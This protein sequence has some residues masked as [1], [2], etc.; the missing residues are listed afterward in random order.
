MD[1]RGMLNERLPGDPVY[2]NA[3]DPRPWR[4]YLSESDKRYKQYRGTRDR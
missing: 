4:T 1:E 2:W 3:A